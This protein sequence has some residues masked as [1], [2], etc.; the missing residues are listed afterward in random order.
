M[1]MKKLAAIIFSAAMVLNMGAA[2]MATG[3]PTQSP[4]DMKTVTITKNY[5]ATNKG[6]TSPAETFNFTIANTS[7]KDAA[8]GVTAANM[9][10]PA[11][12]NVSYTAGEA[13]STTKS[14]DITVT[15]P[16]Y[17]SVGVYT[18]TIK[19]DQGSTAGVTYRTSDI[20][21]V[22]TVLQDASGYIRV[23]AVHTEDE[24][25][26]KTNTFNDNEYSAGS[27]AVKKIVTGNLGDQ[28]KEF[29]VT[30]TFTA[31][32]GKTVSEA[33]SYSDG[34][35]DYT[36]PASAWTSGTATAEINLKHDET[37]TFTNIPYGVTYT[38]KED[39]YTS[40][41]YKTTYA[42]GDNNKKIDSASDSV[43]ITNNKNNDKI[44]TGINLDSMPY[45]M[46]LALV[47][48]CAVV[49]FVRKRFSANR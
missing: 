30:V 32:E 17:R 7:V 20:K 45:I 12:G 2:A 46:I 27:L 28:Q 18:Y 15:L 22:V 3:E 29:A 34:G 4:T 9:P 40:D 21:L 47:A 10:T 38:V 19:E 36:I 14:K 35:T 41:G 5:E 49:M 44:D 25:G 13:G 11:I 6:T 23:A 43:D 16:E 26:N 24:G 8:S 31:P 33:I 1:K 42:F 48:V 37:V 39:D